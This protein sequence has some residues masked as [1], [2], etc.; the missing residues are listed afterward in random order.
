MT[1]ESLRNCPSCL[2][3]PAEVL[4]HQEFDLIAGHPL[5][6]GYDVVDGDTCGFVYAD[7]SAT[8]DDYNEFY[9]QMSKYDPATGTGSGALAWDAE[10]LRDTAAMVARFL[11]SS[12]SRILDLGWAGVACCVV[13]VHWD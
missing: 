4:H 3:T 1:M 13:C 5:A 2:G 12:E 7:T 10:R 6:S 8:Q 11:D 9:E